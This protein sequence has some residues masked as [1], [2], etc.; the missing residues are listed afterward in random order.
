M[1][2]VLL[3]K[4]DVEALFAWRDEHKE[5]VRRLPAPLRAVEIMFTH[6]AIR[7]KGI[8]E[9]RRLKL[10]VYNDSQKIGK[11]E[12]EIAADNML[13]HRK[14]Q[15][16]ITRDSFESILSCYCGLMAYMVYEKSELVESE[17]PAEPKKK[18][19][20]RGKG[21]QK[22]VTYIMRPRK[23]PAAPKGGHHAS[24]RGIFTVRGHYRH[25]KSGKTVWI[26]EYKK[27]AGDKKSKTYKIGVKT[28]GQ[29][30]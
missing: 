26:D 12:F 10:Y 14:G 11:A 6:N 4:D 21:T 8:R 5:L 30:G 1:D 22:Q 3:T 17:P 20:R 18:H 23:T 16:N 2:R 24:P 15:I 29:K 25:Y 9:E 19:E 13:H 7:I 28:D 27:G